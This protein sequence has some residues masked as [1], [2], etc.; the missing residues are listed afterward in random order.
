LR[1]E[2]LPLECRLLLDLDLDLRADGLLRKRM[3]RR[4]RDEHRQ[5][6]EHSHCVARPNPA[7]AP[8]EHGG[9]SDNSRASRWRAIERYRWRVLGRLL[10]TWQRVR[11]GL[12]LLTLRAMRRGR[13]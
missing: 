1:V 8:L 11:R 13:D 12:P 3:Q 10:S 7:R 9:D 2:G 4:G 5:D 6:A